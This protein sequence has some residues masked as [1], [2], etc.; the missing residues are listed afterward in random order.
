MTMEA[1][2]GNAKLTYKKALV[3]SH[4]KIWYLYGEVA[5]TWVKGDYHPMLRHKKIGI[6]A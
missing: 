2:L 1:P 5:T 6:A 4:P 3:N